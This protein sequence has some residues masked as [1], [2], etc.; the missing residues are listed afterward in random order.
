MHI[1]SFVFQLCFSQSFIDASGYSSAGSGTLL[2]KW[3]FFSSSNTV[4]AG[5][6]TRLRLSSDDF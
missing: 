6:Q 5:K 3:C 2:I 1:A 4:M